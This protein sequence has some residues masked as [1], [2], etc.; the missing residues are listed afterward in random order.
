VLKTLSLRATF[1]GI[2]GRVV[3]DWLASPIPD[4][5]TD[6]LILGSIIDHASGYHEGPKAFVSDNQRDF[7]DPMIQD[8]LAEAGVKYFRTTPSAL[9]WLRS[10]PR[11]DTSVET[12][13]PEGTSEPTE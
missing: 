12:N 8:R 6:R 13:R 3:R 9:G 4:D 11:P 7:G 1:I 10:Q 5:P 2:E